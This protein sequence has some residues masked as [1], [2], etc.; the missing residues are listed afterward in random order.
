MWSA[1]GIKG[2]ADDT[3]RTHVAR[4]GDP[5]DLSN[6]PVVGL[7]WYEVL[8][9]ARWVEAE[10]RASG[11]IEPDDRVTLPT[12]AEWEYAARGRDGRRYRWG[13]SP[14]GQVRTAWRR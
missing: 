5:F 7:T 11:K 4:L 14:V 1:E 13:V 8:A 3:P 12:E 10:W 6:H 9:F 2:W